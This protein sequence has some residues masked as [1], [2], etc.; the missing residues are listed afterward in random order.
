MYYQQTEQGFMVRLQKGE[1]I[2]TALTQFM[3]AKNITGGAVVGIGAVTDVALGFLDLETK[4]YVRQEYHEDYELINLTG[5]LSLVDGAPLLHAHVVL[6]GEDMSAI[7][8]HLFAATISVT[9]EFEIT[10]AGERFERAFDDETG[11]KLLNLP[12][13]LEIGS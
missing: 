13:K 5:N 9:G 10:V 2:H 11:L 12:Q 4:D 6:S 8:G 1:E 3:A 7:A